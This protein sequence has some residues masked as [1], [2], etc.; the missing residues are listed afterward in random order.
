MLRQIHRRKIEMSDVVA[1]IRK[2]DGTVGEHVSEEIAFASSLGKK[3][4]N[5]ESALKGILND[6]AT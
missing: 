4:C 5:V 1:I 3:V 6:W 2:K